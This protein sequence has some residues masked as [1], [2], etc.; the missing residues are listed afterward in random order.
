M[1]RN[2]LVLF[3]ICMLSS[4]STHTLSSGV[5]EDARSLRHNVVAIRAKWENNKTN[6]GFG[7]VVGVHDNKVYIVTANHVV[8]G[9][10]RGAIDRSPTVTLYLEKKEIIGTVTLLPQSDS[11]MDLAILE[12]PLPDNLLL[13]FAV[14]DFGE[15]TQSTRVSYIGAANQWDVP[16]SPQGII[17]N[18]SETQLF[19]EGLN[20][21][22]GTSGAPLVG[23]NGIL[24]MFISNAA[25]SS[26][27]LSAS[28][29]T[30]LK[31]SAIKNKVEEWHY[32]WSLVSSVP[33]SYVSG[34]W[35]YLYPGDKP[36][37]ASAFA[38]DDAPHH[39]AF[40]AYLESGDQVASGAG[41]MDG[42]KFRIVY[43]SVLIPSTIKADLLVKV[44]QASSNQNEALLMEGVVSFIDEFGE[45]TTEFMRL[46][47]LNSNGR[48]Y[49]QANAY[50]KNNANPELERVSEGEAIVKKLL[51]DQ[52]EGK[53]MSQ[54]PQIPKQHSNDY[55]NTPNIPANPQIAAM[56]IQ[57][58]QTMLR[59]SNMTNVSLSIKDNCIVAE[60]Q[61]D[62][63]SSIE[64][65]GG[66]LRV[67]GTQGG[68]Q[69][70]NNVT[71]AIP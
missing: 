14:A 29:A 49:A 24:G 21:D 71:L 9:K 11:T 28:T 39:Y 16:S 12:M 18:S 33:I 69:A 26:A 5:F 19:V 54:S 41:V 36:I 70:C 20:V 31:I 7:W 46:V 8:R 34:D 4:V 32:P 68:M 10:K 17:T 15:P 44:S 45:P 40:K 25:T 64:K 3:V 58:I 13:K 63:S 27:K 52:N 47:K 2:I 55:T 38:Y 23:E 56:M 62:E 22:V 60:G 37:K 65:I 42:G 48:Y 30:V 43:E 57:Q 66:L 51:R 61:V 35:H 59:L 1:K 50:M 67:I 53:Q 6:N